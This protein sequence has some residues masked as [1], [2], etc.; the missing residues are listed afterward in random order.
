MAFTHDT[1]FIE[2][3]VSQNGTDV[4]GAGRETD[5]NIRYSQRDYSEQV[6]EVK[7]NTHDPNNHVYMGTTPTSLANILGLPKLPM[8]IT[9]QHVY[10]MAVSEQQAKQEGRYK[11]RMNYH[12]L[13]WDTVKK[14]P[15]YINRPAMII[16][17]NTDPSDA[18]FV[19]VTGETDQSGSRY[20]GDP[21]KRDRKLLQPGDPLQ[22]HAEQ[23][24]K[25]RIPKLC[26]QGKGGEQNSL[27]K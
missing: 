6:D 18:R 11:T 14:L 26:G 20:R 15:E 22:F 25:K 9:A 4:N 7:N 10:S 13:G 2:S 16:K 23:L 21:T 12:A 17:S 8:L 24:R 5:G 3:R 1:P 27:C 19:V